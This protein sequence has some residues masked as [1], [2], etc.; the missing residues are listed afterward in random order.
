MPRIKPLTQAE[1]K[2]RKLLAAITGAMAY[3][4]KGNK[5]MA[6]TMGMTYP[7]W[8]SRMK[9]P[10]KFTVEEI[11]RMKRVLPGLELGI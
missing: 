3:E 8:R 11:R 10:G 4:G 6:E 5:Q 2:D 9:T 7:T 1:D